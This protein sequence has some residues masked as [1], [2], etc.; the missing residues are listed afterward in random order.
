MRRFQPCNFSKFVFIAL[1]GAMA[2][3]AF[4]LVSKPTNLLQGVLAP[5]PQSSLLAGSPPNSQNDVPADEPKFFAIDRTA[6]GVDLVLHRPLALA[7]DVLEVTLVGS[8]NLVTATWSPFMNVTF[9]AGDTN[10]SV[11]VTGAM[12]DVHSVD[13]A[14]FFAFINAGDS[15]GDGLADWDERFNLTTDPDEV[16]SDGDGLDDAMEVDLGT[17]PVRADTDGDGLDDQEEIDCVCE[18]GVNDWHLISGATTIFAQPSA[19][20]TID[21]DIRTV[22]LPSSVTLG[23]VVYDRAS[24]DVNG[25]VHLI[26]V[27]GAPV[28]TSDPD[29]LAPAKHV[30][31]LSSPM[32]GNAVLESED[33]S[34]NMNDGAHGIPRPNGWGRTHPVFADSWLHSDMKDMAFFYVYKLYEQLVQKGN[35]ND[36]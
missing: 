7:A 10:V 34:I 31:A 19:G 8:T 11:T 29:N 18:V 33:H 25:K 13:N 36:Q 3:T 35:L 5:L 4:R 14:C 9:P 26:P 32:G 15:D 6:N 22:A 24:I 16:D 23:G 30:P 21:D 1:F 12:L 28:T 20:T 2:L 27:D 17:N